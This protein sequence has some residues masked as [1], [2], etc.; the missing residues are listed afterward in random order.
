MTVS[1]AGQR[2][3]G[4]GARRGIHFEGYPVTHAAA[5]FA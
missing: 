4:G 2:W 1:S 5:D 3:A